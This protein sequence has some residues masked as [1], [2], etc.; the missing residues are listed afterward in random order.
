MAA[1]I[2]SA[3]VQCLTLRHNRYEDQDNVHYE[4][5]DYTGDSGK[6]EKFIPNSDMAF[7]DFRNKMKEEWESRRASANGST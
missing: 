6:V 1:K 3:L 4:G 5:F 7:I 2:H